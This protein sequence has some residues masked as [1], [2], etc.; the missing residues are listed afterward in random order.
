MTT[1][2]MIILFVV[3]FAIGWPLGSVYRR[4]FPKRKKS[5]FGWS[6][7][8]RIQMEGRAKRDGVVT[9]CDLSWPTPIDQDDLVFAPRNPEI[10]PLSSFSYLAEAFDEKMKHEAQQEPTTQ[11]S[12]DAPSHHDSSNNDNSSSDSTDSG[13]SDSSDTGSTSTD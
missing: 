7:Q 6:K 1:T 2:D 8:T 4:A 10:L 12:D 3:G 5:P 9:L 13:S 11:T